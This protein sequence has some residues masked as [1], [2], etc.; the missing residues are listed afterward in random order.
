M[1]RGKPLSIR[2]RIRDER[3]LRFRAALM[4]VLGLP[5]FNSVPAHHAVNT[6]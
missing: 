4:P 1:A 6:R 2:F 3:L 5:Y